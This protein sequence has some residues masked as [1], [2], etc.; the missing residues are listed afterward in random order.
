MAFRLDYIA[1]PILVLSLGFNSWHWG[2]VA[3][4]KDIGPVIAESA[5]REAPLVLTYSYIGQKAIALAG[6]QERARASAEATFG[7]A[8]ERLLAEHDLTMENLFSER[9]SSSQYWLVKTH[10]LPP[11]ALLLFAI[12]WW[13]RPKKIQTIRTGQR[14]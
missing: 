14:R 13:R 12:G 3:Q 2:S 1:L 4:L 9:F 10:W 6:M 5:A 7:P 11:V 8:R